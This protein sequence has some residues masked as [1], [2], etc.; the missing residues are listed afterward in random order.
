MRNPLREFVVLMIALAFAVALVFIL[1]GC[2]TTGGSVIKEEPVKQTV[3]VY[4][5]NASGEPVYV[6]A[7]LNGEIIFDG[8]VMPGGGVELA[9]TEGHFEM[10]AIGMH[11]QN[12]LTSEHD[13]TL[14]GLLEGLDAG[15]RNTIIL[16]PE[17]K[18]KPKAYA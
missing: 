6:R 11:S 18:E 1:N 7:K 15:L 8:I 5:M 3:P 9:M 12:Y 17:R 2:V 14:E 13:Y 4:L 10:E 16:A